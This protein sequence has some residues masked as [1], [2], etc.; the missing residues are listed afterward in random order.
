M[1][2][3]RLLSDSAKVPTVRYP[4]EDLG[5]DLYSD[6]TVVIP[7]KGNKK[8]STGVAVEY[9]LK[10]YEDFKFGFLIRERSSMAMNRL[11][12]MGGVIDSGYKGEIFLILENLG[13][14]SYQIVAGD[15][16][17]NLIPTMAFTNDVEV[18]P[19]LALSL[20]GSKWNASSGR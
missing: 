19:D 8:V 16:I 18:V 17:A 4:S 10:N 2:R 7:A 5:Y 11:K 15:K 1:L 13:D 9:K 14:E 12:I 20:R 6:E 3:V